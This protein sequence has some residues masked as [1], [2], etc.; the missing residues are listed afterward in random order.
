MRSRRRRLRRERVL[1]RQRLNGNQVA[2]GF[3]VTG[4]ARDHIADP[5]EHLRRRRYHGPPRLRAYAL[6]HGIVYADYWPILATS[7]GAMK[8]QYA[9]D[10]VH[11][12]ARGY[13]A[14]RPITEA[15]IARALRER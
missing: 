8:P 15:A 7:D 4:D 11:P 14:M 10:G 5:F 13:E 6:G 3:A 12:N 9:D 1:K 2:A